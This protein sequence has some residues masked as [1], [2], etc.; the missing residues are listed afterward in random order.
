MDGLDLRVISSFFFYDIVNKTGNKYFDNLE[1]TISVHDLSN[2][3]TPTQVNTF[4]FYI[5]KITRTEYK[6]LCIIYCN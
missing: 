4:R 6:G 1:R 5:K 2:E 3:E